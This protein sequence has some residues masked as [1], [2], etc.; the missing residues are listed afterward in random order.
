MFLPFMTSDK[1]Q[2]NFLKNGPYW[3]LFVGNIFYY[4][5]KFHHFF[6]WKI[7]PVAICHEQAPISVLSFF[8]GCMLTKFYDITSTD[9][10]TDGR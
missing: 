9:I 8:Y 6:S 2:I 5:M 10:N 1:S 7:L 4:L 3:K